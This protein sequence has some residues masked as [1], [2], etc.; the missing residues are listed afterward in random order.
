MIV[1]ENPDYKNFQQTGARPSTIFKSVFTNNTSEAQS[2]SLKTERSSES[3]CGV[4]REQGYTFG[5][6]TELSL[7]TPC[8]V[9]LIVIKMFKIFC[10]KI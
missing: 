2:Y 3:I 9:F 8:N 4:A 7:K 6:E 10:L 5:A 1:H